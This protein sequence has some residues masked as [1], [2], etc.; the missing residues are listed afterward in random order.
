MTNKQSIKNKSIVKRNYFIIILLVCFFVVSYTK[1]QFFVNSDTLNSKRVWG[2]TLTEAGIYSISYLGLNQLW[3]AKYERSRF[4]FFDDSK[5]WLQMD[6]AGHCFSAYYI[7]NLATRSYRW[8]GMPQ[9][10]AVWIGG[11]TGWFYVSTIEI[12]DGFS[13]NW[14]ASV[15]DLAAN[16]LGSLLYI[17]QEIGFQEQRIVLKYSYR[18]T[19]YPQYRPDVLG[20]GFEKFSKDY[21]GTTFWISANI[22]SLTRRRLFPKWLNLAF[23]YGADGMLGGDSNPEKYNGKP[24]PYYKRNRQFY[25]SFD[26]DLSRIKTNSDVLHFFL[27]ALNCIKI[28]LPAI[29][30]SNKNLHFHWLGF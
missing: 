19:K 23:G 4:H 8:T 18:H 3:Y 29:E 2:V 6:K 25:I 22:F 11:G 10:K 5:E 1:G 14:G 16:T 28:P 13:T 24:L 21:N 12:F 17:L 27:R 15:T 20:K 30:Y 9:K 26:L 7:S